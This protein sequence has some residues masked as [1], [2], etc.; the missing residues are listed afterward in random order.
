MNRTITAFY[1][2]RAAAQKV[3]D[4]LKAANLGAEIEIVDQ[5]AADAHPHHHDFIQWLGG[6]FAGHEDKHVY[7]EGLRRGHFLLTAKVDELKETRAAE[8]LEAANP[9]NLQEAQST[10]RAEGWRGPDA[11]PLSPASEGTQ[12]R[13]VRVI[14][15]T[16][17]SYSLEPVD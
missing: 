16:V 17:R 6:L 3:A 7:G 9:L 8:I 1:E 14:G 15:V 2:T 13:A 10:W 4:A 11:Q 12:G 5:T